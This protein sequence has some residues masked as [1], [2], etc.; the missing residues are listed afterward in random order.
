V[1][2][3]LLNV[4]IAAGWTL[5]AS[6]EGPARFVVGGLIGFGF[7]ALARRVL[8]SED[9]VRRTLAL[10][11]FL[12]AFAWEFLAANIAV[13]RIILTQRRDDLHPDYVTYDVRGLRPHETILLSF[14]TAL[15]PGTTAVR[16][17][18]DR[19]QLVVHALDA[20]HPDQVRTWLDQHLRRRILA[21]TR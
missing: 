1:R 15:T 12:V 16:L 21:F 5:L 9:Y 11:R 18:E 14:F 10:L 17:F 19:G 13:L 7:I 2:G 4:A 6:Y 20:R 8:R 3:L